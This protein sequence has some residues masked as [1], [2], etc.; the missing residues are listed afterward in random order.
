M[1]IA[2][3]VHILQCFFSFFNKCLKGFEIHKTYYKA[4]EKDNMNNLLMYQSTNHNPSYI[5]FVTD[6][7]DGG[8]R[9]VRLAEHRAF[10][11]RFVCTAENE[12]AGFA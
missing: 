6:I 1:D 8:Q 9:Q 3:L 4:D 7:N 2:Y 10:P 11:A 12:V 5:H